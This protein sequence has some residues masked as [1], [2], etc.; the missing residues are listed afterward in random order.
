MK[1]HNL[2]LTAALFLTA[3]VSFAAIETITT[4]KDGKTYTGYAWSVDKDTNNITV[5]LTRSNSNGNGTWSYELFAYKG[6]AN[7]KDWSYTLNE[8]NADSYKKVKNEQIYTFHIPLT[9]PNNVDYDITSIGIIS[10]KTSTSASISTEN[11]FAKDSDFF[12]YLS[13]ETGAKDNTISYGK[14]T[15]KPGK[16]KEHMKAEFTFGQPLPAPVVTLLIAL[17][18]G[19]ALVMYRNR[20]QAKA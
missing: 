17:G 7:S 11:I 18:F 1:L 6:G 13:K 4:T 19:A 3:T 8:E 5:T 14:I 15:G 10:D 9:G 2:L 12:Y 16:E 20:K